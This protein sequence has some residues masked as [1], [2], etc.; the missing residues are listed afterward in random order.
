MKKKK[1]TTKKRIAQSYMFFGL[2]TL[3]IA[4]GCLIYGFNDRLVYIKKSNTYISTRAT[5]IDY[6]Y[7]DDGTATEII[8]YTIN[9]NVYVKTLSNYS[10]N[11][12]D[13]NSKITI[14]YNRANPNEIIYNDSILIYF[15]ILFGFIVLSLSI[16]IINKN[17]LILKY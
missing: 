7:H 4:V 8:E 13:I 2:A 3:L 17:Y 11:P 9:K 12:K 5:V 10:H 16:I 15:V 6:D 1:N 14:R